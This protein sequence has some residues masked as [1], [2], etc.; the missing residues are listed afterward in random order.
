MWVNREINA[1]HAFVAAWLPG[2]E[3]IGVADVLLRTANDNVQFDFKGKLPYSWPAAPMQTPLNVGDA[4]YD[5]L[6][7]YGYGL[8]YADSITVPL[9]PE[10]DG[11]SETVNVSRYFAA[12]R[13]IAPWNL[14]LSSKGK[15]VAVQT[16]R[17]A[18][19]DG[20]ISIVSADEAAQEDIRTITWTGEGE[21]SFALTS[22]TP[23]DLSSTTMASMAIKMRFRID[24][25]P[26]ADVIFSLETA[27]PSK[28]RSIRKQLADAPPGRWRMISIPLS[29]FT[30]SDALKSVTASTVITTRGRLK[31]S[32]SEVQL[33][34]NDR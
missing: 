13:A 7:A 30:P 5:P 32:I 9:L 24:A 34:P 26:T 23:V 29:S 1:S 3:G 20:A 15:S 28:P 19:G 14:R 22:D 10:V 31:M 6:F 8:T 11:T 25:P 21:A 12:G 2:S 18:T 33:V 17:A 16:P 4:D 27:V